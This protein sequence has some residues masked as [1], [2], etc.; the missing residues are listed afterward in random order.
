MDLE[1]HEYSRLFLLECVR[2]RACV[3]ASP[4]SSLL[5]PPG[6]WMGWG[7]L[8]LCR[9]VLLADR[10]GEDGEEVAVAHSS[11]C[12][13]PCFL[14]SHTH[15]ASRPRPPFFCEAQRNTGPIAVQERLKHPFARGASSLRAS[16]ASHHLARADC[17]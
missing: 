12:G 9:E 14:A 7:G 1:R 5:W 16:K 4:R 3:R 6:R 17:R 8:L 11:L 10:R 2:V 13:W 15:T